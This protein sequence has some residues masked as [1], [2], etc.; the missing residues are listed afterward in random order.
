MAALLGGAALEVEGELPWLT[1]PPLSPALPHE[2]EGAQ[3]APAS[4]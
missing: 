2:G 3:V 1:L 4:S